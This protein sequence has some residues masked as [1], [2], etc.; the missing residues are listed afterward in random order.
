[1]LLPPGYLVLRASEAGAGGVLEIALDT[2]SL[3]VLG[4]S[5]L[6]AV[7]V[8]ALSVTVAVPLAWLTTRTNLPGRRAWTVLAALP[9][10]I[11]SYVGAFVLVSMLGPRGI[12]QDFLAPLGV[13]RLPS[14][15]GLPGTVLVLVLFTY[16]YVFL[17]VRSALGGIDPSLEE[18]ARG[19]GSSQLSTF[20]KVTLL[21]LR[22]AIAAGALLV[23][24]YTL[25]DFGVVSLLQYDSFTRE[26]YLQYRSAF[27]R[28][29]AAVLA[30]MLVALV[31]VVLFLESLTRGRAA[32]HAGSS[33]A[34]PH[35]PVALGRWQL[36][37]LAYCGGVVL[38]ALAAPVG[39]LVFW[40]LRG[41][42]SGESLN[43]VVQTA[44]NSLQ[45]SA[46]AAGFA[47]LA[48]LPVAVLAARHRSRAASL[49]EGLTYTGFALPG[50]VL[51]LALVFFGAN[52][53]PVLYQ[54]LPLLLFAYVV[55]FMPQAVGAIRSSLLQARPTVEEA[56]RGLGR[57]TL[58]V[59][60]TVTV[61]LARRG[62][63][64]GAALVFLTTMK[65]LPAT[66]L[67]GPTGFATLA[68][69]IWN[70]TSEAF[71]ARAAAPALV[72]I[73]I[74]ALPMY[75]LVIRERAK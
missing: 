3:A 37:A 26:I 11:P 18:A 9:L 52:V 25:S 53:F 60:A 6:L 43:P 65:E 20:F 44:L 66:L 22:P 15:Y 51:A 50:I 27:D 59:L 13:E 17:T 56:A 72:L 74:S 41:L 58:G 29:P 31:C 39:V 42:S 55:H 73:L 63:L 23:A 7:L 16:P 54:T 34:R 33:G 8:T 35:Q 36:P 32:Y 62:I 48:A 68:T 67:L 4:R 70:A 14:I 21:Q 1:M 57:S 45:V 28:T 12:L 61:P 5:V 19:L 46:M 24:L 30:L 40:L 64:A 38:L 2:S 47:V 10:V 49:L 69:Q 71:F 75:L